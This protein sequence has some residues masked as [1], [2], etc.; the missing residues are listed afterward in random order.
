LH[1]TSYGEA[2]FSERGAKAGLVR[3]ESMK[4]TV[5]LA[6]ALVF[7][8]GSA[9]IVAA[10]QKVV[11]AKQLQ[12]LLPGA[13]E[14]FKVDEP[15]SGSIESSP[16]GRISRAEVSFKTAGEVPK[17]LR[18][19]IVDLAE[20]MMATAAVMGIT[21]VGSNETAGG[22]EKPVTVKGKYRG[23]E[24]GQAVGSS[25]TV[26][27][28]VANRFIVTVSGTYVDVRML[29]WLLDAMSVEKLEKLI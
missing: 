29:Y 15:A 25:H 23:R 5:V 21:N 3:E 24:Q 11:D 6:L 1:A 26:D 27:F 20:S 2:A 16:Y 14:G 7:V 13:P 18:V 8:V 22:Y 17:T 10:Q 28:V 9:F 4:R 19:S 12:G